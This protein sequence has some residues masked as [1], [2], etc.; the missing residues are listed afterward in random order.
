MVVHGA[1]RVR[2]LRE[3][4]LRHRRVSRRVSKTRDNPPRESRT[5]DRWRDE[6]SIDS[7]LQPLGNAADAER[8]SRDAG[9]GNLEPDK[10]GRLRRQGRNDKKVALGK[11][12]RLRRAVEPP[13]KVDGDLVMGALH[14]LRLALPY[15]ASGTVT[16]HDDAK[17][18][19]ELMTNCRQHGEKELTALESFH[20]AEVE[21]RAGVKRRPP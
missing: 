16:R 21:Q 17:T 4:I 7:I 13:W 12:P 3:G 2:G 10:G 14:R 18:N 8:H 9:A 5:G 1:T 20:A 11:H 6:T 19:S 15:L